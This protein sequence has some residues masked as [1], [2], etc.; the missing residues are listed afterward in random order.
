MANCRNL[1]WLFP[2][3]DTASP[4]P[5][6]S[7][8]RSKPRFWSWKGNLLLRMNLRISKS[9]SS[10]SMGIPHKNSA[11]LSGR[12]LGFF[13]KT[14][15]FWWIWKMMMNILLKKPTI[16]EMFIKFPYEISCW[17]TA[18]QHLPDFSR[19][20]RPNPCRG[21]RSKRSH[22]STNIVAPGKFCSNAK[23]TTLVI[24]GAQDFFSMCLTP[25]WT[26]VE[27]SVPHH[28]FSLSNPNVPWNHNK[29]WKPNI[30]NVPR[31]QIS[32]QPGMAP[33]YPHSRSSILQSLVFSW[34]A[35]QC[36]PQRVGIPKSWWWR[37]DP[38]G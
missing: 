30:P 15:N 20:P 38:K 18:K 5:T 36:Q 14:S 31:Y 25:G 34:C 11:F 12:W 27:R 32:S 9:R 33:A 29:I 6:Y 8:P 7:R 17:K 28:V 16:F 4:V 26:F 3:S 1:H 13:G 37:I 35:W 2:H 21:P 24:Q 10:K 19:D 22:P 23:K